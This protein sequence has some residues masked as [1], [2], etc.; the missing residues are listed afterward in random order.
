MKAKSRFLSSPILWLSLAMLFLLGLSFV[1]SLPAVMRQYTINQSVYLLKSRGIFRSYSHGSGNLYIV[2]HKVSNDEA[3]AILT[4]SD[5]IEGVVACDSQVGDDELAIFARCENLWFLNVPG[6]SSVTSCGIRSVAKHKKL[7]ALCLNDV[8][9]GDNV[10]PSLV[11]I[12][13][14]RQL[15]IRGTDISEEGIWRLL[16]ECPNLQLLAHCDYMDDEGSCLKFHLDRAK[17]MEE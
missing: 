14:L 6:N 13:S 8:H 12:Q 15:S 2:N 9:V 4:L 11:K 7:R 1:L 16:K 17:A 3:A 10:I 5:R